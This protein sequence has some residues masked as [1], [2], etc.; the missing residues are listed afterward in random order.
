MKKIIVVIVL[1]S[2][3]VLNTSCASTITRIMMDENESSALGTY[4]S[5]KFDLIL[6]GGFFYGV[7]GSDVESEA[8]V[9]APLIIPLVPI[10]IADLPISLVTDTL[11]LPSDL[12]NKEKNEVIDTEVALQKATPAAEAD[13]VVREKVSA[14]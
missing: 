13:S 5:T 4:K 14:P 7:F 6:I 2:V 9:F 11:F 3:A 12:S 10:G 8:R 1:F